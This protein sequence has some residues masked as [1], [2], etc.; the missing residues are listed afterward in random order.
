MD[1]KT[2]CNWRLVKKNTDWNMK[3]VLNTSITFLQTKVSIPKKRC[4]FLNCNHACLTQLNWTDNTERD[5]VP[6]CALHI[7]QHILTD[8]DMYCV[9]GLDINGNALL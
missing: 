1:L 7:D 3:L 2:F 5:F 6:W 4:S 9:G 8:I